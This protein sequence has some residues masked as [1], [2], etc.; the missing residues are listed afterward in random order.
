MLPKRGQ[1]DRKHIE[2]VVQIPPE[3][4]FPHFFGEVTVGGGNHAHIDVDRPRTP[5]A[6]DLAF[7]QHP[8]QLRLQFERQLAN[9]VEENRAAMR[10][11]EASDLRACERR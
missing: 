4:D 6:F 5:E 10:Q 1:R 9:L 3:A 8:Q 2:A 7:L 11:L